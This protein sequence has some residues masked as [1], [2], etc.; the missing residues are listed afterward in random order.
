MDRELEQMYL[1]KIRSLEEDI[2]G[3][4]MS[5]RIIMA[6]LEENQLSRRTENQ[7]LLMENRRLNKKVTAYAKRLWQQN[8]QKELQ[9]KV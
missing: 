3:L 9:K 8:T 5:R 6:L 7:R 4:R 1:D 2:S